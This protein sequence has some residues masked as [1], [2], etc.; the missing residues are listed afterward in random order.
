MI[1]DEKIM[2]IVL[3]LM[4]YAAILLPT[5]RAYTKESSNPNFLLFQLQSVSLR[6]LVFLAGF[7][8]I[9]YCLQAGPTQILTTIVL[10]VFWAIIEV[11]NHLCFRFF[12]LPLARVVLHLPIR[13][14]DDNSWSSLFAY[15]KGF[16][17]TKLFAYYMFAGAGFY[18]LYFGKNL[19]SYGITN[20]LAVG[21]GLALVPWVLRIFIKPRVSFSDVEARFLVPTQSTPSNRLKKSPRMIAEVQGILRVAEGKNV[22]LIINE[23]VGANATSAQDKSKCL[24]SCL[25]ELAGDSNHWIVFENALTAST[26][27]DISIPCLV[28]GCAPQESVDRLHLLPTIFDI[29]KSAGLRTVFATSCTLKWANF[30]QFF[31]LDSIDKFLGPIEKN[32]PIVNELNCDDALIVEDLCEYLLQTTEPVCAVVYLNSL[33]IPFQSESKFGFPSEITERRDRA[34]YITEQS[35]KMIFDVLKH[36]GRYE[37]SLIFSVGDHGELP[38]IADQKLGNLSRLTELSTS[39]IRPL[40]LMRLPEPVPTHQRQI[41]LANRGA[42]VSLIDI[43]PTVTEF[44]GCHLSEKHRSDGMSLFHSIPVSRIHYTLG[45]NDW[46]SWPRSAVAIA[47]QDL[48][49]CID[50]QAAQHACVDEYGAP[51]VGSRAILKDRLLQHALHEPIVRNAISNIFLDKLTG[52]V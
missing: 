46:R 48:C 34:T 8:L 20:L 44:L 38:Q 13:S 41:V 22:I 17:P 19:N 37:S 40:C 9:A 12:K 51:F 6:L 14:A 28:T 33:H 15:I 32:Y 21:S 11:G 43:V 52:E 26:C 7:S 39:V 31:A 3:L 25:V 50:Y 10:A 49:V 45:V 18:V 4:F 2:L 27:T 29:A 47:C 35:H 30:D 24:A 23:S 5:I 16:F 42:L 36:S 1:A